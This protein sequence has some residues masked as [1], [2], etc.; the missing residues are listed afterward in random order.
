MSNHEHEHCGCGCEHHEHDHKPMDKYTTAIS[1]STVTL[2][3]A[4]MTAP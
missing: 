1:Q 4:A 2:D 3:D